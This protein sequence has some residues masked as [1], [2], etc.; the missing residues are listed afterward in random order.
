MAVLNRSA[1]Y[2]SAALPRSAEKPSN[3]RIDGKRRV[4]RHQLFHCGSL[5]SGADQVA[6]VPACAIVSQTASK[7]FRQASK[8]QQGTAYNEMQGHDRPCA[9]T[10]ISLSLKGASMTIEPRSLPLL[11]NDPATDMLRVYQGSLFENLSLRA[12]LDWVDIGVTLMR[13]TQFQHVRNLL[14]DTFEP[15]GLFVA[16]VAAAAGNVSKRFVIRLQDVARWATLHQLHSRLQQRFGVAESRIEGTEIAIDAQLREPDSSSLTRQLAEVGIH[17]YLRLA[18]PLSFAARFY[19]KDEAGEELLREVGS[20]VKGP[21]QLVDCLATPMTLYIGHKDDPLAMRMYVKDRDRK[22][23]LPPAEYRLRFELTVNLAGWSALALDGPP[24]L[25]QF[26][27]FGFA[28]AVRGYFHTRRL[29]D[30]SPFQTQVFKARA[31]VFAQPMA[32]GERRVRGF[33]QRAFSPSTR[34]D[35]RFNEKLYDALR[36]L[37]RRLQ[38]GRL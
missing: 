14:G 15:H 20:E 34:A 6:W 3:T 36:D 8:L 21:R 27:Q 35:S 16:P 24:T 17:W 29:S 22:Q 4:R 38:R 30:L 5:V 7:R 10:L 1:H 13:P 33:R 32:R 11:V 19:G 25:T 31:S 12:S 28:K 26:T 9:N 2:P 23:P 18:K 37:E